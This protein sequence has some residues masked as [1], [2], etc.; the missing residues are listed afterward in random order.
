MLRRIP[1]LG[2]N[3]NCARRLAGIRQLKQCTVKVGIK[4]LAQRLKLR[5]AIGFQRLNTTNTYVSPRSAHQKRNICTPRLLE[6]IEAIRQC[7][8]K[9]KL[10]F[11]QI[12]E[13]CQ[14]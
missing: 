7:S 6:S 2:D 12:S 14:I 13:T 9:A 10:Q 11:Q 3:T 4:F 8:N 5:N 1:H